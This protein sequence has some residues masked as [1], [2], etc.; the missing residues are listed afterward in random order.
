MATLTELI[1]IY[2]GSTITSTGL[3]IVHDRILKKQMEK[4]FDKFEAHIKKS[5]KRK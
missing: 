2:L 5:I 3:V 4:I 1:L